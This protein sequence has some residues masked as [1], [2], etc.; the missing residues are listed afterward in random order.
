MP[1]R[2]PVHDRYFPAA[3]PHDDSRP[4]RS[5]SLKRSETAA[6]NLTMF[7]ASTD[8]SRATSSTELEPCRSEL[9]G[10]VAANLTAPA[11]E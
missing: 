3:R 4:P 9:G 10:I 8:P 5:T 6:P 7:G 11:S 2:G 1:L